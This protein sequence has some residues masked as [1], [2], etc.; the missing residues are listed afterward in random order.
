VAWVPDTKAE[1]AAS[2]RRALSPDT[3]AK[4]FISSTVT[5]PPNV[6][7]LLSYDSRVRKSV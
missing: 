7:A 1:A 4:A 2:A 5:L 3:T 6:E